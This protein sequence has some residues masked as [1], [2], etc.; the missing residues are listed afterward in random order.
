MIPRDDFRRTLGERLLDSPAV[1]LLG[2][3]QCGKTTL[4]RSLAGGRDTPP[5]NVFDLESSEDLAR[6]SDPLLALGSLRGLVVLDEI[7]NR[8][9]LFS[10]LRVLCDRPPTPAGPPA[11]FLVLGSAS[12]TLLNQSAESLAGRVAYVELPPLSLFE[13]G[14]GEWRRLWLRG[15]FPRAYDARSAPSAF[16]WLRDYV[17]TFL[18]RDLRLVGERLSPETARRVWTMLAHGHGGPLNLTAIGNSLDLP[19]ATVRRYVDALEGAFMIRLLK[20]WHENAGKR[21]VKAPKVYVRDSGV[22]HS[23]LGLRDPVAL[24]GSPKLGA[25]WE[26]FA[27]ETML[28]RLRHAEPFFWGA[29]SGGEVDLL[30]VDG[31][32]R[33]A[34]DFKWSDAPRPSRAAL[35]VLDALGLDRLTLVPPE[36]KAYPLSDR[37]DV[38]P[39][40]LA[41]DDAPRF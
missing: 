40:A 12:P 35:G 13:T 19:H 21:V 7:Q 23:L 1:A 5:E 34:Y 26:G 15:G 6:L 16:D 17:R 31:A 10:V 33:R 29:H 41:M 22:L 2:P 18:E 8:P 20:P 14:P 39:L 37:V 4:A 32:R 9:E 11:T 38:M 24:E 30:L 36:G 28:R 25:S 3:R 27:L